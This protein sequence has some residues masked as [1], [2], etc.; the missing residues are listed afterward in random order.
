MLEIELGNGDK[1]I[2]D[3]YANNGEWVGISISDA[4]SPTAVGEDVITDAKTVEGLKPNVTIKTSNPASLDVLIW[5]CERAKNR[6][7]NI[8]EEKAL[9]AKARE[10]M[11]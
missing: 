7:K 1:L 5:A 2:S 3:I 8:E 4:V 9:L 11:G 6:L 10:K